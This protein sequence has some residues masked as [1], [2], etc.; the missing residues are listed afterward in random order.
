MGPHP[1][2]RTPRLNPAPVA[3]TAFADIA[4]TVNGLAQTLL[5]SQTPAQTGVV[6]GPNVT[7]ELGMLFQAAAPGQITALRFWKDTNDIG[8]H[9]G[10][11]WSASGQLLA[12]VQFTNQSASG[13]QQQSLA[14]PL[15]IQ[16]GLGYVVSVNTPT[17]YYVETDSG[18]TTPIVNQ[19]LSTIAG[20]NGVYGPQGQFPTSW[21]DDT[22]Y[23]RDVVFVPGGGG[24]QAGQTYYYVVT[25][26]GPNGMESPPSEEK[27]ASIP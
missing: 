4:N 19:Y 24:V 12:S 7:Y 11:I 6:D 23:F 15:S 17:G 14:V 8:T 18:L 10:N 5:T 20:N 27:S 1:A 3:S 13:W 9:V 22:N 21:F 2:V 16:A 26:V 25:S